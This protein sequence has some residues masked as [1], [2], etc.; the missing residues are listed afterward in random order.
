TTCGRQSKKHSRTDTKS[1][2]SRKPGQLPNNKT[3]IPFLLKTERL[4]NRSSP[5]LI[6]VKTMHR[7]RRS[8][9]TKADR[10]LINQVRRAEKAQRKAVEN[11]VFGGR[12]RR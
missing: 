10:G 12:R 8:P 3:A 6:M 9:V 2:C 4:K 5:S 1:E 7:D 11:A